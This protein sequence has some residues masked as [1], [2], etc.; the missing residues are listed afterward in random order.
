MPLDKPL[1]QEETR[2]LLANVDSSTTRAG[3]LTSATAT[4]ADSLGNGPGEPRRRWSPRRTAV[5][6]VA[7]LVVIAGVTI[8]LVD[9]FSS[10]PAQSATTFSLATVTHRSLS[11]QTQVSATLGYAGSYS[12]VN[13]A[14]GHLTTLPAVGQVVANGQSLYSVDGKPVVLLYGA[15][16]A[17][18]TISEGSSGA[19]VQ[20]LNADLVGLGYATSS[21]LDPSSNYFSSETASALEGLQGALGVTETGS[22]TLG[23][24]VFLPSA[25]RVTTVTATLGGSSPPGGSVLTATSTTRQVTVQLDAALQ[26]DVKVGDK[27]SIT[28]PDHST[29][30]GVVSGVGT[31][32]TTPSGNSASSTPTI[33]VDVTPTNPA[34]TGSLDQAP[35]QVAITNA[36]VDNALVVPVDALLALENGGY[37]L[38]VVPARGGH[39]LVPV[40]TG[41]FDDADGLVQVTGPGL[42][43]GMRVVV[44]SS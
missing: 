16:P 32:A 15:V 44:P 8:A 9:P 22:M 25:V 40:T 37:A 6:V 20:Q 28:L 35:V 29:T 1:D 34:A 26:A 41:L 12:V 27:V 7:A 21:E 19:D 14:Q 13:Q 42:A 31:V 18:R 17:Y 36:T 38:E 4:A 10:T 3:M 23:D 30:P 24:A 43:P 33:E 2:D 5:V 39:Y 11:S